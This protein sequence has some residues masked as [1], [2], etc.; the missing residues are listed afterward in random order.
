MKQFRPAAK[1]IILD[2]KIGLNTGDD[3]EFSAIE[4]LTG[5]GGNDKFKCMDLT[6]D[7]AF[8]GARRKYAGP[9]EYVRHNGGILVGRYHV[10]YQDTSQI[11][12]LIHRR[13]SQN[14]SNS[15]DLWLSCSMNVL[16]SNEFM[17]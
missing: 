15:N 4:Y 17:S 11:H 12:D 9:Y 1:A 5:L 14:M 3:K 7:M 8:I 13:L 16:D 6:K 2:S 10:L